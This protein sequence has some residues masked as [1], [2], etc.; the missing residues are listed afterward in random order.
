MGPLKSF[1]PFE[2]KTVQAQ[3]AMVAFTT[4][5]KLEVSRGVY[6]ISNLIVYYHQ[7]LVIYTGQNIT[8]DPTA[9]I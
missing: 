2:S 5:E 8:I 1:S 6:I 4:V 3:E 9:V 7:K